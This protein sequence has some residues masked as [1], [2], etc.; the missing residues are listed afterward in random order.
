[1][2]VFVQGLDAL[3]VV[4]QEEDQG[5]GQTHGLCDGPCP[6]DPGHLAAE[7]QQVGG[8][9]Q[10]DELARQGD[11]GCIDAGTQ[12]LEGGAQ[13]DAHRGHGE[14][15]GD[16]AQGADGHA[17]EFVAGIEDG[18][19][20]LGGEL[21]HGEAD[22]HDGESCHGGELQG[23]HHALGIP[24]TVVEGHDGDDGVVDAEQRHEEEGLEL[25]I[26]AEDA[27]GGLGEALEDLVDAEVHDGA[28]A[29]HDDGGDAHTQDRADNVAIGLHVAAAQ[30]LELLVVSAVQVHG[31]DGGDPLTDDGGQS[32]AGD[33]HFGQTEPAEDQDGI[34]DDVGDR[35]HGL[36]D[37]GLEG[38]AAGLK[39]TLEEDLHE[40]ADGAD[41]D[42]G[43]IDAAAFQGLGDG[44]LA[45]EEGMGEEQAEDHEQGGEQNRQQH[46]VA[47]GAVGA[48]VVLLAQGFRQQGIDAHAHAGGAADEQVLDGEGQGKGGDGGLGDPGD[49]DAV[50]DVVQRLD[51]H[52]DH[53]GQRHVYKEPADGPSAHLVA[54]GKGFG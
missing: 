20:Q 45:G 1:M 21:E 27:G 18:Q 16:G 12:R 37:H 25:E 40:D 30:L 15:P 2:L 52:G 41:G 43:E 24:G 39:E 29:H 6:P 28:D 10:H 3:A 14:A 7:A 50:H 47:R 22:Q 32:G 51:E 54:L 26:D 35:A 8:G 23:L 13:D 49:I 53:Q 17:H 44:G 34:Q 36:G 38:V 11:D 42:D 19:Q 31:Q 48:F 46:A 5:H 33:A 4:A 9:Q